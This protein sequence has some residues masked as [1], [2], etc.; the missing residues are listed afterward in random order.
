MRGYTVVFRKPALL[1]GSAAL[2]TLSC[3][4]AQ[5]PVPFRWYEEA[6]L[7][8]GYSGLSLYDTGPGGLYCRANAPDD[9]NVVLIYEGSAFKEDFS[10][11]SR[12][13]ILGDVAF[14]GDAGFLT[15]AKHEGGQ[16]YACLMR[17]EE[18]G[19]LEVLESS[20]YNDF[21]YPTPV[22]ANCCWL[23][24]TPPLGDSRIVKYEN[25]A[26]TVYGETH[27][28]EDLAYSPRVGL[29]YNVNT[30]DGEKKPRAVIVVTGDGG[31]SWAEESI[32]V[33]APY[34][35]DRFNDMAATADALYLV[36]ELN[37][38]G[39][40]TPYRA[41][42]KRTGPPGQGVYELSYLSWVG[43]G[44]QDIDWIAFRDTD[45]GVATG[46]GGSIYYDA[47]SWTRETTD[48]LFSFQPESP[49]ADPAS[50]YWAAALDEKTLLRHP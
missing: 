7:P 12:E 8:P 10:I 29:L 23:V 18:T 44:T 25:G 32:T 26:L 16:G 45:H 48:P 22:A 20:E 35:L 14:S 11:S 9:R 5:G 30:Y 41:I 47:P 2:L 40:E 49:V 50:G 31:A 13:G 24:A 21:S 1:L 42:I 46:L 38:A 37:L 27:G 39:L 17:R 34:K 15:I 43:P 33:P 6:T 19:W 28:D 4:E 36:A 3:G